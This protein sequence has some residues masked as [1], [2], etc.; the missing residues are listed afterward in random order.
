MNIYIVIK[1]GVYRHDIWGVFD[2]EEAARACAVASLNAERDDYHN[3]LILRMELG[4]TVEHEVCTYTREDTK[5]IE[6]NC[7]VVDSTKIA[8]RPSA[9][10]P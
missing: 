10:R 7:Y 5:H 9:H 4:S 3:A 8:P 6:G 2:N 1:D